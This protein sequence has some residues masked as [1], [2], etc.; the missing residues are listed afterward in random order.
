MV[1]HVVEWE[2]IFEMDEFEVVV[3]VEVDGRDNME[4]GMED[5]EESIQWIS[6]IRSL[7]TLL[8]RLVMGLR[9]PRLPRKWSIPI[10]FRWMCITLKFWIRLLQILS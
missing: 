10:N 6:L 3:V 4:L 8:P 5:I 7:P 1:V 9:W 2:G